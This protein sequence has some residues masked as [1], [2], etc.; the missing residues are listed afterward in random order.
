MN[1][2]VSHVTTYEYGSRVAAA[3]CLLHLEPRN[4]PDQRVAFSGLRRPI[5]GWCCG[6]ARASP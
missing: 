2:D 6:P 3:R 1:Y 4:L 5:Q